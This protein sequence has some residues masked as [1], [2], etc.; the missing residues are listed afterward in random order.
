MVSRDLKDAK[1]MDGEG[2]KVLKVGV[3]H[4]VIVKVFN[5]LKE[6]W[7]SKVYKDGQVDKGLKVDR[8]I[9]VFKDLRDDKGGRDDRGF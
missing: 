9:K 1:E 5:R 3:D 6:S 4:R 7:E 8:G 2:G